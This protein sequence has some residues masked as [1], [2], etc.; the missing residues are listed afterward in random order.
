MLTN[1]INMNSMVTN[2]APIAIHATNNAEAAI[3]SI[4]GKDFRQAR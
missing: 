4:E 1:F 3:Y 2:I